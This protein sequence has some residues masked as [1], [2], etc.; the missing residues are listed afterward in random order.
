[1]KFELRG[2][3]IR[4]LHGDCEDREDQECWKINACCDKV[5]ITKARSIIK[6]FL[7]SEGNV[8]SYKLSLRR[9]VTVRSFSC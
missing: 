4:R 1:M 5:A 9:V 3:V 8:L 2:T 6:K 7:D